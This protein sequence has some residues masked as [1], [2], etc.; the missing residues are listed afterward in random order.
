MTTYAPTTKGKEN[1]YAKPKIGKCYSCGEPRHRSN[2]WPK[3]R[4]V[5]IVDYDDEDEVLIESEPKDSDFFKE[6]GKAATCMIRRLLCNQKNPD[7]TQRH[8][9]FY[10]DKTHGVI[11]AWTKDKLYRSSPLTH[12]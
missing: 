10:D 8:Q 9:I 3:R 12:A 4:P 6:E 2:E 1:P 5:N 7:T 11:F